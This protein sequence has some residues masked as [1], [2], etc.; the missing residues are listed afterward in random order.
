V[1]RP[2]ALRKQNSSTLTQFRSVYFNLFIETV[3]RPLSIENDVNQVW[4]QT[5][6]AWITTVGRKL[7]AYDLL[8]RAAKL[9]S[10]TPSRTLVACNAERND[11]TH[12]QERPATIQFHIRWLSGLGSMHQLLL[13]LSSD[14]F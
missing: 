9:Y 12:L 6:F 5:E 14:G 8:R 1:V 13:N 3:L 4:E 2:I 7:Q 11:A 10:E